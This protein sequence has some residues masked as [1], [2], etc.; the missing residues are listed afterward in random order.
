MATSP[1]II[2]EKDLAARSQMVRALTAETVPVVATGSA[3]ELLEYLLHH[4]CRVVVVGN[5]VEERL[6]PLQLIRLI[7]RCNPVLSIILVADKVSLGQERTI[8]RAGIFYHTTWPTSTGDWT[9][10]QTAVACANRKVLP[11]TPV[12]GQR[13]LRIDLDFIP[14]GIVP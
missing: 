2:A 13:Q 5:T 3:A 12:R 14:K 9:E 1:I 4:D 7:K 8:R 10:L 6:S 11:V